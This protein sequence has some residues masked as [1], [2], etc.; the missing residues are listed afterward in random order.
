ML[1]PGEDS[2]SCWGFLG[3]LLT[4]GDVYCCSVST[5]LQLELSLTFSGILGPDSP[6]SQVSS[7]FNRSMIYLIFIGIM[8]QYLFL[9]KHPVFMGLH[10]VNGAKL[11]TVWYLGSLRFREG[12]SQDMCY[13]PFKQRLLLCHKAALRHGQEFYLC[14]LL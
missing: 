10:C 1:V 8:H 13:L 14:M 4:T 5:L 7:L 12:E 9:S 3:F 2:F 11:P 6:G